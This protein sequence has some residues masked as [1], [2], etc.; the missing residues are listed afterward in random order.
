MA[1]GTWRGLRD[2]EVLTLLGDVQWSE[3]DVNEESGAHEGKGAPRASIVS[4]LFSPFVTEGFM[5]KNVKMLL[6]GPYMELGAEGSGEKKRHGRRS[7]VARLLY[8]FL[9]SQ[10]AGKDEYHA[11]IDALAT[12][13]HL[14]SH[15]YKSLQR[16]QFAPAALRCRQHANRSAEQQPIEP[17]QNSD[18]V[19][20]MLLQEFL[21]GVLLPAMS[22]RQRPS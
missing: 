19:L 16:R 3:R 17:R 13:F 20:G 1:A 11:R 15:A 14:T 7:E 2:R 10:L 8:P 4:V 18:D 21:H 9:D 22:P 6:G 12:R 5:R